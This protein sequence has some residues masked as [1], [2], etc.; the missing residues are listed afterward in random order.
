LAFTWC[1]APQL[2]AR[3]ATH[4]VLCCYPVAT[5]CFHEAG[6]PR[7]R[8]EEV[9]SCI[10]L[11]PSFLRWVPSTESQ[12]QPANPAPGRFL[13]SCA[14]S[15]PTGSP[16]SRW[17]APY[18]WS[19]WICPSSGSYMPTPWAHS[20]VLFSA[21]V[22]A[23]VVLVMPTAWRKVLAVGHDDQASVVAVGIHCTG[24]GPTAHDPE[25]QRARHA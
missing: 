8:R 14:S 13:Q 10:P 6:R 4:L 20:S 2:R 9:Y 17:M 18:T 3:P 23:T 11:L 7:N 16:C 24:D 25:A 5:A 15:L 12:L 21:L 19:C 1:R 22:T